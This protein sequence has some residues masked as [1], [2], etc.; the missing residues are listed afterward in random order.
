MTGSIFSGA[1]GA[2]PILNDGSPES[3]KRAKDVN[4]KLPPG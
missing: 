2:G 1:P 4:D 3:S